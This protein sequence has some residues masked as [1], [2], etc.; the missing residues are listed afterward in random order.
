MNGKTRSPR[1]QGN[2]LKR[3][4]SVSPRSFISIVLVTTGSNVT[5][6]PVT[7]GVGGRRIA[8]KG[9]LTYGV[10]RDLDHNEYDPDHGHELLCYVRN[11]DV[12]RSWIFEFVDNCR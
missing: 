10:L 1:I 8:W 2:S 11:A 9:L 12:V 7:Q 4:E 5:I 3:W 6:I